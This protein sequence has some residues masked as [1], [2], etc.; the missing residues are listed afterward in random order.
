MRDDM[1]EEVKVGD[2]IAFS[3]GIPRN[4][5]V[6]RVARRKKRLVALTPGHNPARCN[7]SELREHVGGWVKL[8][9]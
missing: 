9:E 5:V 2:R 6:A 7:L 8:K 3:Y 1:G 4:Y